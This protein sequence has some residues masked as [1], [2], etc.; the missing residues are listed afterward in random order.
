M[1]AQGLVRQL[2]RAHQHH[3][4]RGPLAPLRPR[5]LLPP[6]RLLRT[7]AWRATR[8]EGKRPT[9]KNSWV[10]DVF[11][12]FLRELSGFAWSLQTPTPAPAPFAGGGGGGAGFPRGEVVGTFLARGLICSG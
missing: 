10:S 3:A 4:V 7:S 9:L 5:Q 11:R 8:I 12:G 2:R 1:E 6:V